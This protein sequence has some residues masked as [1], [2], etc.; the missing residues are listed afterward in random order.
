MHAGKLGQVTN[1]TTVDGTAKHCVDQYM[2]LFRYCLLVGYMLGLPRISSFQFLFRYFFC[3]WHSAYMSV[4]LTFMPFVSAR[5]IFHIV[6]SYR[7]VPLMPVYGVCLLFI[8]SGRLCTATFHNR[9]GPITPT[10]TMARIMH[11]TAPGC[12]K[13]AIPYSQHPSIWRFGIR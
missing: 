2:V 7:V 11:A 10:S 5:Q 4:K 13:S 1:F 9:I 8:G 6:S 12:S 3:F